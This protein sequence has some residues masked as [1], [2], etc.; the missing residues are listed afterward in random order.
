MQRFMREA[1]GSIL[2]QTFRNFELLAIDDASTAEFGTS[3]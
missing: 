3:A 2:P 1:V